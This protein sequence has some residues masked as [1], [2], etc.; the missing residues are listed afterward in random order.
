MQEAQVMHTIRHPHILPLLA[1]FLAC[2]PDRKSS[3]ASW[4]WLV[5][6][7]M[8]GGSMLTLLQSAYPKVITVTCSICAELTCCTA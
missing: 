5:L 4:L 2:S 1:C 3:C 8:T 7:F 6:P